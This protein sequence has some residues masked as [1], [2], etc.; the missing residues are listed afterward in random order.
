MNEKYFYIF[1]TILI[2]VIAGSFLLSSAAGCAMVK[3]KENTPTVECNFAAM[4]IRLKSVKGNEAFEIT[5]S[6]NK[7]YESLKEIDQNSH[8][9][10]CKKRIY[11]KNKIDNDPD[12]KEIFFKC[13]KE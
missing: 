1:L 8:L 10:K 5:T 12:K 7:C 9:I 13:L 3:Y 11:G 2:I 6:L 4:L